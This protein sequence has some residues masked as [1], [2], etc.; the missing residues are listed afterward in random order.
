MKREG[1]GEEGEE[2]GR[3][4]GRRAEEEGGRKAGWEEK[5]EEQRVV[6]LLDQWCA[7][8]I[9]RLVWN[10]LDQSKELQVPGVIG[11]Q[12]SLL[13]VCECVC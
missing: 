13:C 11:V 5:R 3:R 9:L 7:P 6:Y 1:G 12:V 4:G 8:E 10:R 2:G